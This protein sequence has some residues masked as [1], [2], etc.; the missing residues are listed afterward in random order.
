ML[1]L[2]GSDYGV[3]VDTHEAEAFQ[4]SGVRNVTQWLDLKG[5]EKS[6]DILGKLAGYRITPYGM[7][8]VPSPDGLPA[9]SVF[10]I[11]GNYYTDLEPRRPLFDEIPADII[12][13]DSYCFDTGV[14]DAI[15]AGVSGLTV[16]TVTDLGS[17]RFEVRVSGD[18]SSVLDAARWKADFGSGSYWIETVPEEP[19]G[20]EWTFDVVADPA[21]MATIVPGVDTVD[22]D[23]QCALQ[24]SCSFCRAS[25]I[26]VEV[27]PTEVTSDPD[28]LLDGVL[29]RL[30]NKIL[31]TIPIHVRIAQ[32]DHVTSASA[33]FDIQAFGTSGTSSL[34]VAQVGYYFDVTPA[35]EM[36][37][38]QDHM[39]A[40]GS[41]FTVP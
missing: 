3:D 30:V 5:T 35:D 2:L 6:Y 28:F 13:A 18:L 23:Y 14:K 37:L 31:Q 10:E 33:S 27:V 22:I 32:I 19:V 25:V 38:D 36:A 26:R 12:P 34:G 24:I 4:R 20:G 40:T 29:T 1:A 9:G 7:W 21:V 15:N 17:N 11:G 41:S 8:S 16:L 39:I